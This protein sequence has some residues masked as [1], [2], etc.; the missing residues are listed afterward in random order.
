MLPKSPQNRNAVQKSLVVQLC[1]TR[2]CE[3]YPLWTT[4]PNGVLLWLRVCFFCAFLWHVSAVVQSYQPAKMTHVK[5]QW[6]CTKFCFKLG[7][8]ASETHRMLK[9]AFGDNTL[10]QT[11]TYKWFKHFKN[12]WM[13]VYDE[14]LSPKMWQKFDIEGIMHKEFVPPGQ[15]VNRKFCCDILRWLRGQH[16]A[17]ISRQVAQNLLGPETWQRFGAHVACMQQFLASTN[18]SHPPPSLLTGHCPLWFPSPKIEI[19]MQRA[20]FWRHWRDADQIAERD[21]D[22]DAKWLSEVLLIMEV[23]LESPYRCQ[24]EIAVSA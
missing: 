3:L 14:D 9:E 20:T 15:T 2:Y 23:P 13:S 21:E 8:T 7:K 22:A 16:P 24:I 4:L 12:G 5:E 1:A 10:G 6:F 18:M 11:Q 19:E 17:H